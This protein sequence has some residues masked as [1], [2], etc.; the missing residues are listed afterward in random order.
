MNRIIGIP[1]DGPETTDNISS[2]FGHCNYFVGIEIYNDGIYKKTFILPNS[3][4]SGC[5]EPVINMKQRNVTDMIL[6][7]IGMR[8]FMGFRQVNINLFQGIHGS[9][10]KNI[11]MLLEGKLKILTNSSCGSNSNH[12][13]TH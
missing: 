7:G 3:G 8:P 9:I 6:T 11:Q 4:H 1:S 5:M 13:H 10:E 12:A 2:H